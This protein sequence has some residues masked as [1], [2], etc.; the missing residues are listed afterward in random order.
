MIYFISDVHLGLGNIEKQKETE[1]AFLQFLQKI[2]D[3]CDHLY[4]IGDLFDYWF[5]YTT[6]IPKQYISILAAIGNWTKKGKSIDY[7]MGNH[8][9][10]H[11]SFFEQEFGIHVYE[12]DIIRE[13][14]GKR[15]YLSHGDGKA[16]ND[17]GYKILKKVLRNPLSKL[18]FK[19][20]HPDIGI[21]MAAHASKESR[22]YTNKK[23]YESNDYKDGMKDFA[24]NK[25][26]Q[27]GFDFVI[28]GHKH[29]AETVVFGNGTYI[30]LGHWLSFPAH[31]A[32]FDGE[33]VVLKSFHSENTMH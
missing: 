9:F 6:V 33:H 26:I 30:N 25:I 4:I 32:V 2:E 19:W 20:I 15:F 1:Q 13:H 24:Q 3:D 21:A 31:Y 29:K 11:I 12:D 5:E 14:N 7:L 27:E 28:M 23:E 8:D 22:G 18:L 16:Y 17:Q 10:G